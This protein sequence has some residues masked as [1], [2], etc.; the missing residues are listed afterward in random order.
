M[1]KRIKKKLDKRLNC[2]HYIDYF[3]KRQMNYYLKKYEELH[4]EIGERDIIVITWN[5]LHSKRRKI[6]KFQVLKNCELKIC[7]TANKQN[8]LELNFSCNLYKSPEVDKAA[9]QL[10]KM[11]NNWLEG[12][13]ND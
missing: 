13:K 6:I 8:E 3:E 5:N 2:F 11:Y 1:N 7:N 4:G 10:Q 12:I 9:S